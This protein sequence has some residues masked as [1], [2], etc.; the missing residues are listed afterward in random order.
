MSVQQIPAPFA[1]ARTITIPQSGVTFRTPLSL[2]PGIYSITCPAAAIAD[3]I[4]YDAAGTILSEGQTSSGVLTLVLTSPSAFLLVVIDTGTD[5]P[6]SIERTGVII[7]VGASGSIDTIDAT[8]AYTAPAPT[9]AN[10]LILGGGGGGCPT[11]SGI[12]GK[13]GGGSGYREIL[14]GHELSGSVAVVIGAGGAA[15]GA[16]GTT[17]FDGVSASGGSGAADVALSSAAGGSNGGRGATATPGTPGGTN[18]TPG[19][20]ETIPFPVTQVAFGTG[21]A[22]G[23]DAIAG[24]PN[25]RGG[26]GGGGALYGGG[27]GGGR[28]SPSTSGGAGGGGGGG[29]PGTNGATGSS[30]G[31]TGGPGGDGRVFVLRWE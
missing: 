11:P 1:G 13:G 29:V 26:G 2:A 19:S 7:P 10:V 31:A 25:T 3:L 6:V 8:G 17:T 16:G 24:Y 30:G 9:I 5:V 14:V 23:A 4:I 27:G 20:G 22:V 18:G 15:L 28:G 12:N 21:G